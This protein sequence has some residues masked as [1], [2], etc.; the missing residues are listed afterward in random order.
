MSFF[1]RLLLVI[2][3]CLTHNS[4]WDFDRFW[5]QLPTA[6]VGWYS[7]KW[8]QMTFRRNPCLEGCIKAALQAVFGT[9]SNANHEEQTRPQLHGHHNSKLYWLYWRWP[10]GPLA[11][12]P[13]GLPG[14]VIELCGGNK[15]WNMQQGP[16]KST[17]MINIHVYNITVYI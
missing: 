8:H 15:M 4:R 16:A 9:F 13:F 7:T 11:L 10:F 12:W 6:S 17:N 1:C 2:W 3:P 14:R 5:M